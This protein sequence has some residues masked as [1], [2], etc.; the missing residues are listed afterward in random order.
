M[1]DL[2]RRS[3][4]L[5]RDLRRADAALRYA[6]RAG[7]PGLVFGRYGRRVGA[8]LLTRRV[9]EGA[10]YLLCPV[11]IVRYFELPFALDGLPAADGDFLDVSS[12]RLFGF[13][14]A[15]TRP[16]CR[17]RMQNPHQ[18]DLAST[19][20]MAG[21]LGLGNVETSLDGVDALASQLESRDCVWSISVVEHIDG[22][23]DDTAAV[24]LM[25]GALRPGGRLVLTVPVDRDFRDEFRASDTYGTSVRTDDAGRV[26]FQR[27][28]DEAALEAR[29]V[30]PLTGARVVRRGWFGERE[31]GRFAAYQQRWLR[32]G[33]VATLDDPREIADHFQVYESWG[34]MP[35][36]GVAGL[37][38]EKPRT[39]A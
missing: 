30:A 7:A 21:A 5:A 20:R 16:G 24:K 9:R 26:F 19:R 27:W 1:I 18:R 4:G 8:R 29:L 12:P 2:L 3:L 17:V 33:R 34:A 15:D 25:Y 39:P 32:E 14:V 6:D 31:P 37:V 10:S 11:S 22:E 35:G 38:I 36:A 13:Y 28:Y 23:I